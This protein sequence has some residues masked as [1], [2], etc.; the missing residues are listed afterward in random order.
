MFYI[1][2]E[3]VVTDMYGNSSLG[4]RTTHVNYQGSGDP[5]PYQMFSDSGLWT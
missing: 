3:G 2:G 1:D 5:P 4:N